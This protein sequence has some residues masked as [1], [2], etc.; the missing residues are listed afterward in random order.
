MLLS[1]RRSKALLWTVFAVLFAGIVLP[2]TY[3]TVSAAARRTDPQL[4]L[5]AGSLGA[6]PARVLLRVRLPVLLPAMA[7]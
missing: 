5:V 1:T 2:F 4:A 3:S 7:A 6:G